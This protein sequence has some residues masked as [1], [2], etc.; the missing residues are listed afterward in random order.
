MKEPIVVIGLLLWGSIRCCNSSLP[1][2]HSRHIV[3][4]FSVGEEENCFTEFDNAIF[5]PNAR[6]YQAVLF[7]DRLGLG[8][9]DFIVFNVYI[10]KNKKRV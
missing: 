1:G 3:Q 9:L 2:D 8:G 6:I 10:E 4:N 7:L 5:F